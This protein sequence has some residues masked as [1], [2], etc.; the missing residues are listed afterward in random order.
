MSLAGMDAQVPHTVQ[1][2]GRRR[3]RCRTLAILLI[4]L[5]TFCAASMLYG[6]W[7]SD[8]YLI[9]LRQSLNLV[10]GR[11]FSFFS[12]GRV[13]TMTSPLWG[14]VLA[15]IVG[16]LD[17]FYAPILISISLSLGALTMLG[18]HFWKEA[19]VRA[20]PL[21]VALAFLTWSRAFI[22]FSSSGL[23]N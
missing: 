2:G 22:D 10:H 5:L 16:V 9:G 23:E 18:R 4:V 1:A 6:G 12:D 15:A 20:A 21:L 17:V 14:L 19:G 11:G 8:D 3:G 7:L 13:Q